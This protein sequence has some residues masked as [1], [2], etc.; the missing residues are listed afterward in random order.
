[1]RGTVFMLLAMTGLQIGTWVLENPYVCAV[2]GIALCASVFY[3]AYTFK[4]E[5]KKEE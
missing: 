2:S 5:D 4:S 3:N 1:M